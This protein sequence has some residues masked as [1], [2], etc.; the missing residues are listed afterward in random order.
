M[1]SMKLKFTYFI[2]ILIIIL[3]TVSSQIIISY[4]ISRQEQDANLINIAGR[5][6]MLSQNIAKTALKFKTS[7]SE[8]I[9][10]NQRKLAELTAEWEEKHW[11]LVNGSK[12]L[13]LPVENNEIIAKLYDE[14]QEPF[15]LVLNN[16]KKLVN[17]NNSKE[18]EDNIQGILD[19]EGAFLMLMNKIV[20]EY[21]LAAKA[22]V[23]QLQRI[24]IF[25]GIFTVSI[26]LL[27]LFFLIRPLFI[28]IIKQNKSLEIKHKELIKQSQQLLYQKELIQEQNDYLR[29]AK[30]KA[31]D[32]AT[33]KARFLSNMSHEIRTPM[34]AII[35][36]THILL[37]EG[38][39][40][41]QLDHLETAMFSAENLLVII[42]DILDYSKIEAGKLN[43]EQSS[44]NFE[45]CINRLYKSLVPKAEKKKLIFQL[46]MDS[47]LPNYVIGDKTRLSQILINL[48]NNAIKFTKEGKV[49]LSIQQ[50]EVIDN[51]VKIN[52]AVTDTGIG[53][54]KEKQEQIFNSFSQADD[55]TTRRFG[56]T[57]LGLAITK[58]LLELHGSQIQLDSS[59]NKG[60]TFSFI[61]TYAIGAIPLE[62]K[63][64][65]NLLQFSTGDKRIKKIL[66]VENNLFNIKVAQRILRIWNLEID[67]AQDGLEAIEKIRSN[68]YGLVLMDLQMP[69]MDGY[70]ATSMIRSWDEPKYQSLPIIALSAS[71]RQGFR[72]KALEVGMNDYITK[73][74]KP[75]ELYH[76]IERHA[77][78]FDESS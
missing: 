2:F 69:R 51:K 36:M 27:E 11:G 4:S 76:V 29:I 50:E 49:T 77:Q 20:G 65:R 43:I 59:L 21:E 19:N 57:G 1:P 53:I 8:E 38:P 6:R 28:K 26:V 24:E 62:K 34:N 9:S 32:A 54:A 67:I 63:S 13:Q 22:K 7:T 66:V 61:L 56:G 15:F 30:E 12:E 48:V 35:G 73:P 71:A 78:L 39:R 47:Q 75:T 64:D 58:K 52:F 55:D 40:E 46:C 44:F 60:S 3:A 17:R 23:R 18:Y 33:A 5:Q 10:R 74:F 25:I 41:D 37:Q 70:E 31:E 45:D 68:D 14:I 72:K 16:A 42:N